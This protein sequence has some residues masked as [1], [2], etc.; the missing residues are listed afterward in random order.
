MDT[1][2]QKNPALKNRKVFVEEKRIIGIP[3]VYV[4]GMIGFS[5]GFCMLNVF[6]GVF[7]GVVMITTLYVI[8]R[9]DPSAMVFVTSALYRPSSYY[10][11]LPEHIGVMI[12]DESIEDPDS[13]TFINHLPS[14]NQ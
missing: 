6:L 4:A 5:F 9:D 10:V 8:H 1:A 12:V 7:F 14:S 2:P 13:Y 11:G 3:S